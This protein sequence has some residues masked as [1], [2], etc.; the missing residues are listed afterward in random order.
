MPERNIPRHVVIL[1][2]LF[3]VSRLLGFFTQIPGKI[4]LFRTLMGSFKPFLS[5]PPWK[6]FFAILLN[7]SAKS[8][9]VL[10]A[11]ILLGLVPLLVVAANGYVLGVAYLYTSAKVGYVQAAKAVLPHGVLEIPAVI[12][13]ASHGLWI[14]VISA[15]VYK[16]GRSRWPRPLLSLF[17]GRRPRGPPAPVRTGDRTPPPGTR[18]C[19]I[20]PR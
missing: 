17:L 7:N 13:V 4:D 14:G 12:L 15:W 19:R 8:F 11:G 18:P 2:A 20:P 10:L 1:S 9:A 6:M 3:V 5:L 16:K